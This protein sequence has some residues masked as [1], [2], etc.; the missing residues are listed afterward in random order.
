MLL[1]YKEGVIYL[2][3][4]LIRIFGAFQ[5]VDIVLTGLT[6]STE[7]ESVI[8]FSYPFHE[9]RTG[10]L[11]LTL[12]SDPFFVFKPLRVHIWV[13]FLAA[14]I[15]IGT[16]VQISEKCASNTLITQGHAPLMPLFDRLWYTVG[17]MWN[18]GTVKLWDGQ[19]S[20]FCSLF[21]T[22][23]ILHGPSF[24]HGIRSVINSDSIWICHLTSIGNPIVD[25]RLR[26]I[27]IYNGIS[28]TGKMTSLYW[29]VLRP[30]RIRSCH[31]NLPNPIWIIVLHGLQ[32]GK[33]IHFL[34]MIIAIACVRHTVA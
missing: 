22:K 21:A 18:Q 4:K 31:D 34:N 7:R 2:P 10:L 9:E 24:A 30:S 8:D 16:L 29:S 32:A 1:P 23:F 12:P 15:L 6:I 13:S 11:T 27:P 25:M 19:F 28:Y 14:A 3:L 20:I 5:D 33:N 17:A 26:R